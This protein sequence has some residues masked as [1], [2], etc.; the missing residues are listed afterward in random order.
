[1]PTR[2]LF[3]RST[4]R[5]F[6]KER[7][8]FP[9]PFWPYEPTHVASPR[10]GNTPRLENLLKDGKIYLS[11]DDAVMLALENN[12]DIAIA[13]YN[14]DIADTDLLRARAGSGVLGVPTGLVTGTLGG[15]STTIVGG[16]GPGGTSAGAGGA[17]AGAG[18]LVLSENGQGPIPEVLDPVLTGTI[19]LERATSPQT[20]TFFSGPVVNQNTDQYNF[21]Y[22]QGFLTGT[23]LNVGYNN[24]RITSSNPSTPFN[25]LLLSSFKAQLTQHLLQGFGWGINGRFIVQAKNDRRITDS[26]FRQQLLY[27][28]NQV[29]NIYWALVSGYE[30]VQAKERALQQ[31]KQLTADNRKQLEIGTLAPLDVVNSDSQVAADQQALIVSQTNLEYQQ[32]IIKQAIARNLEDPALSTAPVIPTD[33]VSLTE[34]PE[35]SESMEDLVKQAEANNPQVE[36]SLL[37]VKND[38]ITR[39]ALRNGL[40]PTVD[41]FAFYGSSALGGQQVAGCN[42]PKNVFLYQHCLPT[43]GSGTVFTHLFN[44]SG[45]DKGAGFNVNITLRNRVAQAA[46]ARAEIEY[47]QAQMRLQQ[48]YTQIRIQVINQQY[49]LTEDRAQVKAAM[50]LREFDAQSTEAEQKK[51]KLGASTTALVLAQQRAL[52]IAENGVISAT[53]AYAKDR[54]L[55]F[56]ILANTLDR[57][58]ISLVEATQ[59]T[60]A[61]TPNIPGLEAPKPA[62][63]PGPVGST[64]PGAN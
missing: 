3:L 4:S 62:P 10:L 63:K 52:A 18:G 48:L 14:L 49:A 5:N 27:T 12:F 39:K 8:Y 13:R 20:F 42:D 17:G 28:I 51:F 2:P 47:R 37:T 43:A 64:P 22:N 57:Y 61:E 36:Q 33:R 15:Q 59:G 45:P 54:A 21:G 23:N 26:A 25:A 6:A 50:A 35:E 44:S 30:D 41:A 34:V 29:E 55:L 56:Q 1:M 24:Q 40:L 7:G 11:L 53:A 58:G 19:Q 31:T 16:G 46:Q 60:M 32:L 9:N 38:E